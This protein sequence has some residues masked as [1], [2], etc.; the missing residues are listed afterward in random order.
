MRHGFASTCLAF[1][2]AGPATFGAV[3]IDRIAVI[4]GKHAILTSDIHRDIRLTAFLN[5]AQIDLSV[6]ARRQ[7]AERL[8]DQELIRQE[9]ITGDYR[10]PT[11]SDAEALEKQLVQDRFAGSDAQFRQALARYSLTEDQLRAQL[12]WQLT[13]LR[14]INQRF[15]AGVLVS[16]D[17]A[18]QYYQQHQAE[19][20]KEN[21]RATQDALLSRSRD[22][23]EGERINQNFMDWLDGTRKSVHIEYK[24]EAFT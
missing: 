2:L 8:I 6:Q 10:R 20:K 24:Q 7:S 19:L 1:L 18:Q 21:P 3:T 4:V 13:V 5:R 15:R 17:E 23:L 12:L 22:L 11:N 14:F 16:D 9:I